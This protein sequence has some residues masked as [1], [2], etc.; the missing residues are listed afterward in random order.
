[1]TRWERRRGGGGG[2]ERQY[3]KMLGENISVMQN[4]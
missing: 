3:Y 2:G 1:M 4:M